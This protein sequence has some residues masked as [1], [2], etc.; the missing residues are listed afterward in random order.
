LDT[1]TIRSVYTVEANLEAEN[2][3][4]SKLAI[5]DENGKSSR[6]PRQEM[7]QTLYSLTKD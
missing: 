6:T 1:I 5:M 2:L 4:N 3:I 7:V